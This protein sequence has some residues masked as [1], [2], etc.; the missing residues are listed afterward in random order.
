MDGTLSPLE[1]VQALT[2]VVSGDA[3]AL[4]SFNKAAASPVGG[5]QGGVKRPQVAAIVKGQVGAIISRRAQYGRR[6]T[7]YGM[8]L[9]SCAGQGGG[10]TAIGISGER[11]SEIPAIGIEVVGGIAV[12]GRI[13]VWAGGMAEGIGR[14][15]AA[16]GG[17]VVAQVEAIEAGAIAVLSA[18]AEG[19]GQGMSRPQRR[20]IGAGGVAVTKGAGRVPFDRT[21]RNPGHDV[22]VNI[23]DESGRLSGCFVDDGDDRQGNQDAQEAWER[24][25]AFTLPKSVRE[26]KQT[27]RSVRI[28]CDAEKGER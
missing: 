2:H 17:I 14:F 12:E 16:R 18:P 20:G 24:H 26:E 27:P 15:E 3:D 22:A 6:K 7:V 9:G 5:V 11:C 28:G 1:V 4:V 13:K 8:I 23:V 21:A 25:E 19:M 10:P